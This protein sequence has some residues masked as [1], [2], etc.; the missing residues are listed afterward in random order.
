MQR[1]NRKEH[2]VSGTQNADGAQNA[3]FSKVSYSSD[4][5]RDILGKLILKMHWA[6]M[7]YQQT[8]FVYSLNRIFPSF[9]QQQQKFFEKGKIS[10]NL[11]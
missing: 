1:E 11:Q 3:G 4:L 10:K 7:L 8:F 5:R 6:F 9:F 2:T